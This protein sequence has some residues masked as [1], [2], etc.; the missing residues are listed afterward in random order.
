MGMIVLQ[1]AMAAGA[2]FFV[3]LG[4]FLLIGVPILTGLFMK[5]LWIILGRQD[6]IKDKKPYYKDPLLYFPCLIG[7]IIILVVIFYCLILL[8]DKLNPDFLKY[9]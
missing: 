5:M 8:F 9:S 1:A 4:I 3:L 6:F 2:I 7:S